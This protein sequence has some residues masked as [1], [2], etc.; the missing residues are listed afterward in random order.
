MAPEKILHID[1]NYEWAIQPA[2]KRG[3]RAHHFS[4]DLLPKCLAEEAKHGKSSKFHEASDSLAFGLSRK[5][6]LELGTYHVEG[7]TN[8]TSVLP[9]KEKLSG[10]TLAIK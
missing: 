4:Q 8:G 9:R 3:I 10:K 1:D 7:H 6:S 5:R 2:Q